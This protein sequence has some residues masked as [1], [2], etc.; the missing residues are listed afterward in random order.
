MQQ[1]DS[2][3]RRCA[4]LSRFSSRLRLPCTSRATA[5]RHVSSD[6]AAGATRFQNRRRQTTCC[7]SRRARDDGAAPQPRV[8]DDGAWLRACAAFATA[9]A[10]ENA[11]L[12]SVKLGGDAPAL[13]TGAAGGCASVLDSAYAQLHGVPLSALGC[14][15]YA[16]VALL[17]VA[18]V[19]EAPRG[20]LRVPLV[21]ACASLAGVSAYLLSLLLTVFTATPCVYC[22]ASA[23]LSAACLGASWRALPPGSARA[24]A[25]TATAAALLAALLVAM[26]QAAAEAASRE[27]VVG[28]EEVAL[29]RASTPETTALAAHLRATGWRMFG[30]FWCS[31]CTEQKE[32]FGRGAGLPYVECFPSGWSRD[33]PLAPACEAAHLAGF[34]TWV[35]PNGEKMEGE[36]S[37]DALAK[38]SGF[39]Q[40]PVAVA[41][42]ARE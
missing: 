22:V 25:P 13:C 18:A 35:G 32:A 39:T 14:A 2:V 30:A 19:G 21:G 20:A 8:R 23:S 4:C 41:T 28:Y 40:Q 36:Q 3:P 27:A 37:L 5:L 7:T 1:L 33:T 9:G 15:A 16:A 26:P 17:A 24:A 6:S 34:P 31:H 12:T 11:Y 38:L 42:G 10:V 29:A